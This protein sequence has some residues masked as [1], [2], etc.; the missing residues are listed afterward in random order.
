ML[1]LRRYLTRAM[2]MPFIRRML[3]C[4]DDAAYARDDAYYGRH[5]WRACCRYAAARYSALL[6]SAASG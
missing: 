5:A 4:Y 6:R 1:L 2:P 3:Q